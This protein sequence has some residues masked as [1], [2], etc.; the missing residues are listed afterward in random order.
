MQVQA[1]SSALGEQGFQ[2]WSGV[3]PD[4]GLSKGRAVLCGSS[5]ACGASI[6]SPKGGAE[7]GRSAP[8]S[9][10]AIS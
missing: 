6:Y 10:S 1:Q 3:G 8:P 7:S 2:V 9:F 5:K 4:V